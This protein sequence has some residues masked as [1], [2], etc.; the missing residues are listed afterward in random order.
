VKNSEVLQPGLCIL[1]IKLLSQSGVLQQL[2]RRRLQ[3]V[4]RATR[5]P[6]RTLHMLESRRSSLFGRLLSTAMHNS[7]SVSTEQQLCEWWHLPRSRKFVHLLMSS[8]LQWKTLRNPVALRT[9]AMQQRSK[10]RAKQRATISSVRVHHRLGWTYLQSSSNSALQCSGG[11]HVS[12]QCYMLPRL[13]VLQWHLRSARV[14]SVLG[15][16]SLRGW[17]QRHNVPVSTAQR[18]SFNWLELATVGVLKALDAGNPCC[19]PAACTAKRNARR[20]CQL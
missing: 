10:L 5:R 17:F 20:K 3:H 4:L 2:L 7:Q 18:A 1:Q 8:R 19:I 13:P 16:V 6:L 15:L 12:Q 9:A 11:C 14:H